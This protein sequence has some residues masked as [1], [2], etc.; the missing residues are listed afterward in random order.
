MRLLILAV[1][2]KM[3]A[4]VSMGFEDY[5]RRMP[6]DSMLQLVEIRPQPRGAG[7]GTPAQIDRMLKL[8]ALRLRAAIPAG[9]TCIALD[10][11]GRTASTQ[12]LARLLEGWRR[13][14]ADVVFL[15]GGADGL[16][17]ELKRSAHLMLSLSAM[18]LPHQLV[19]VLLAEQLYRA[20][21]LL[22]GHPYHRA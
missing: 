3:P 19:R 12:D 8:E 22:Q 4:W 14:G 11:R 10:E 20:A 9:A 6:R 13:E 7:S 5:A 21:S 2:H 15:I 16:E 18:T 1:G 17:V